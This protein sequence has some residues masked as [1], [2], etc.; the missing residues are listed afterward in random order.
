MPICKIECSLR[1][2]LRVSGLPLHKARSGRAVRL[3]EFDI[4][5]VPRPAGQGVDF[6][7]VV[8]GRRAGMSSVGNKLL[9]GNDL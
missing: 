2:L 7:V 1:N 6:E 4:I 8:G 9:T 3:L 5:M